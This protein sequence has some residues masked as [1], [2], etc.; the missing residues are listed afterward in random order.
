MRPHWRTYMK[1]LKIWNK[2]T[3][4]VAQLRSAQA[5]AFNATDGKMTHRST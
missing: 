2:P 5:G 3:I 1:M 4:E